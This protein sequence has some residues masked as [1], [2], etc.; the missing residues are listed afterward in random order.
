MR[1][2][3]VHHAASAVFF[4]PNGPDYVKGPCSAHPFLRVIGGRNINPRHPHATYVPANLPARFSAQAKAPVHDIPAGLRSEGERYSSA[5]LGIS[6]RVPRQRFNELE[7]MAVLAMFG[8][9]A[10]CVIYTLWKVI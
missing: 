1:P 9:V 10:M 8:V 7:S 4:G 2:K 6:P 3:P 5:P